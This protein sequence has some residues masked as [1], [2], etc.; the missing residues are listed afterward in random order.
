M[1][2]FF[3]TRFKLK[4]D[5]LKVKH[6]SQLGLMDTKSAQLLKYETFYQEWLKLRNIEENFSGV[7]FDNFGKVTF[8]SLE[9]KF[10]E[11]QNKALLPAPFF[12]QNER[13]KEKMRRNTKQNFYIKKLRD[14]RNKKNV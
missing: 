11:I 8:K 6:F 7:K 4:E 14:N 13:G 9:E 5:A 1:A 3:E 12:R 10:T 2:T